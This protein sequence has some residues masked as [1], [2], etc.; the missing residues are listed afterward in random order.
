M[1]LN[2]PLHP[3]FVHLPVVLIPL[4]TL[5]VI[6]LVVLKRRSQ[7]LSLAVL[8]VVVVAAISSIAS[9]LSGGALAELMGFQPE[10][11]A[12]W[13]LF[14]M[15]SAIAFLLTAAPWLWQ[16]ARTDG[17]PTGRTL[18]LVASAIGVIACV[19][20]FLAGHSGATMSWS[21]V[22]SGSAEA[23]TSPTT[24]AQSSSAPQTSTSAATSGYTA[25][26]VAKHSTAE[27]CWAIVDG[28][29]YDLTD[30]V[31]QH[32]GGAGAISKMCG[33]DATEAFQNKHGG[34][35]GP[36]KALE[37]HLLGPVS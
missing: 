19:F 10:T 30:W 2:L 11:H 7:Q 15:I 24:P 28:K 20:T 26:E 14:L 17:E 21:D 8:G 16:V 37:R 25:E 9:Y 22:A 1:F 27:D 12:R 13:G 36:T 35:E 29:V 6:A 31:N 32:P 18:G 3:L 33:T 4:A 34:N 5:G 23:T